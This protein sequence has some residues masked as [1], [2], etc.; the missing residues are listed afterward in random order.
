MANEE[1]PAILTPMVEKWNAWRRRTLAL[2]DPQGRD[3]VGV[4]LGGA[5][6]HRILLRH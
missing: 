5:N 2:S 1:Q 3:L 4:N 6:L